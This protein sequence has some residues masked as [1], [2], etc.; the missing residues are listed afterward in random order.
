MTTAPNVTTNMQIVTQDER[1]PYIR[2]F[3]GRAFYWRDIPNNTYDIRDIAH[4]LAMNCRWTGHTKEF[5]SVAQHS[6]Y[7]SYEVP[8][9]DALA[10]LLHDAAEAYVHDTSSPLK[11]FLK[12]KG[13][14]VFS[15]LENQIEDALMKSFGVP[16][17]LSLVV[18]QVDMRLWAT[19]YRDLM[20]TEKAVL[21]VEKDHPVP[22]EWHVH[23]LPPVDAERVFL[24]R[25]KQ[26]TGTRRQLVPSGK[27]F[28]FNGD[29]LK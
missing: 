2:T 14:T 8:P 9:N 10:A 5:Y 24:R 7:A 3:T 17:P 22:F 13:F 1:G 12:E 15:D 29:L 21:S 6:V 4:A 11:K 20:R 19:E 16:F 27:S 26:L 28:M 25:F 18:K 23:P